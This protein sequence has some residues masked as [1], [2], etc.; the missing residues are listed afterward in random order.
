MTAFPIG[1][2]NFS[3]Q[4][5]SSQ[6]FAWANTHRNDHPKYKGEKGRILGKTY[7]FEI[8]CYW[9]HPSGQN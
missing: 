7:G 6:F 4:Q 1:W 9:E 3:P 5:G 8:R 2:M